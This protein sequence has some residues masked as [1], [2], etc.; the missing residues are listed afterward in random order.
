MQL[1]KAII[2]PPEILTAISFIAEIKPV[3]AADASCEQVE[4]STDH[5]SNK[6]FNK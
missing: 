3:V 1:P 5:E 6:T 2:F 4:V